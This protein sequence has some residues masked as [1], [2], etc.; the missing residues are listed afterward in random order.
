MPWLKCTAHS[1]CLAQKHV[2]SH[3]CHCVE[4]SV[5]WCARETDLMDTTEA[6]LRAQLAQATQLLEEHAGVLQQVKQLRAEQASMQADHAA[7][8]GQLQA[9]QRT[10]KKQ[11][12][13]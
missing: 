8:I 4:G 10:M 11:A 5:L 12:T 3:T 2:P 13:Q 1:C 9:L 6:S 7:E